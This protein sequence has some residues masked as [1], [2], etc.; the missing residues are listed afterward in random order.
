MLTMTNISFINHETRTATAPP[1]AAATSSRAVLNGHCAAVNDI[2]ETVVQTVPAVLVLVLVVALV[3]VLVAA[4][5][6]FLVTVVFVVRAAVGLGQVVPGL[7]AI[8]A[9]FVKFVGVLLTFLCP[10]SNGE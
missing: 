6:P 7:Q 1:A 10:S 5:A 2:L 8:V 4:A 3:F 9:E